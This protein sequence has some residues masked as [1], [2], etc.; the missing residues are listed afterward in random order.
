MQRRYNQVHLRKFTFGVTQTYWYGAKAAF[1]SSPTL[2]CTWCELS[3]CDCNL[4]TRVLCE[5]CPLLH[6]VD[7]VFTMKLRLIVSWLQLQNKNFCEFIAS[8]YHFA[9]DVVNRA[10]THG[11]C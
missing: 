3:A 4:S 6:L 8:V 2:S 11:I 7:A 9:E 1:L 10:S 5:I